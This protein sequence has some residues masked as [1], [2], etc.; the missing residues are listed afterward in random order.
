[1]LR[2]RSRDCDVILWGDVN[3][4]IHGCGV[5]LAVADKKIPWAD[6]GVSREVV[7]QRK[8]MS[9]YVEVGGNC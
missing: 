1:M 5:G 8:I 7:F 3:L 6:L 9:E 2:V 4:R